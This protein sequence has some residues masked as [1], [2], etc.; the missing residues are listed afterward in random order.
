MDL[1]EQ[2]N[3]IKNKQKSQFQPGYIDRIFEIHTNYEKDEK[4]DIP[5]IIKLEPEEKKKKRSIN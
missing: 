1:I 5:V 4:G 2:F 3:K